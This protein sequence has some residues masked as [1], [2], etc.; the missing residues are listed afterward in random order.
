M[1]LRHLRYFTEAARELH[2]ARAAANLKVTQPALSRQIAALEKELG[3]EL[4]SRSNKWKIELTP[5]G[6][7]FRAEAEKILEDSQRA[8]NLARSA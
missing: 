5:V 7:V 2:F 4:F 3:V 1:E 8:V 6:E